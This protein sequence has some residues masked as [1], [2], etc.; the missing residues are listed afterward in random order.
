ML[1]TLYQQ[2]SRVLSKKYPT[3]VAF[4]SAVFCSGGSTQHAT[5]S[6]STINPPK[7]FFRPPRRL[8]LSTF[9]RAAGRTCS[10]H[11]RCKL[12]Y[13][14]RRR[15]KKSMLNYCPRHQKIRSSTQSFK[16]IPWVRILIPI[17]NKCGRRKKSSKLR[18]E[19]SVY[20]FDVRP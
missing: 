5:A 8:L 2:A 12:T 14:S 10:Y 17:E 3:L 15:S 16:P 20:L 1:A 9:P 19:T 11:E 7:K 4:Q 6:V 18:G 13:Q